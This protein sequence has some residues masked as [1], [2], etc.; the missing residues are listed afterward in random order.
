MSSSASGIETLSNSE[1]SLSE[2]SY[3]VSPASQ[4]SP[5]SEE[6]TA[7]SAKDIV[8]LSLNRPIRVHLT[9]GRIVQG[10]LTCFDHLGNMILSATVDCTLR[11]SRP[12]PIR[13]GTVLVPGRA[14]ERVL[15]ALH[16]ALRPSPF[17][18]RYDNPDVDQGQTDNCLATQASSSLTFDS[19]GHP[20]HPQSA[21]P[22][23]AASSIRST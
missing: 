12:K 3:T 21:L 23:Q 10:I 17:E 22:S 1:S 20:S 16:S 4:A 7:D 11:P 19:H 6:P 9:D 8:R 15:V 13:L 18:Q 2:H 5:Q 14:T